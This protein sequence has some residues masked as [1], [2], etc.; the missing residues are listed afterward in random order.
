[1]GWNKQVVAII[2][3]VAAIQT[4]VIKSVAAVGVLAF[5]AIYQKYSYRSLDIV[6]SVLTIVIVVGLMLTQ[7]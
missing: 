1:M 2:L 6:Y 3:K 4:F 5:W 7:V